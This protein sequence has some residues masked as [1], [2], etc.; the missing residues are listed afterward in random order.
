[1]TLSKQNSLDA[2]KSYWK[3]TNIKQKKAMTISLAQHM[4]MGHPTTSRQHV[5][6]PE[7]IPLASG[8]SS[9]TFKG[10]QYSSNNLVKA[11]QI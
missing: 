2:I 10:S 9:E 4:G 6:K 5:N 11:N 7:I 1:M 8:N 3:D